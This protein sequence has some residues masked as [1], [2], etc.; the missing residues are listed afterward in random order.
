MKVSEIDIS[1]DFKTIEVQDR[2]YD[3]ID[4]RCLAGMVYQI[5]LIRE[6]EQSLLKLSADGCVHGPVHTSIGQEACAAGTMAVLEP[7]DQIASTHRAHHHYLAK[8]ISCYMAQGFDPRSDDLPEGLDREVTC[9]LGEVMGLSIG[10]CGGRGGSMHLRNKKIGVI[11]TNAIVAGG[12]PLATG[13]AYVMKYTKTPTIVVSFFGD[14]AVNQGA[15]HEALNLAG[16]WKIPIIYFIENN[17]YAVATAV[18]NSTA[19]P[20]LAVKALAYGIRARVVDGMDPLAVMLTVREAKKYALE[21][22]GPTVIEAKCYRFLHH[23]GSLEGSSFSYRTKTEEKEWRDKDPYSVFSQNLINHNI[24][25]NQQIDRI[26]AKAVQT[27]SGAVEYCTHFQK[28]KRCARE[29]LWPSPKTLKLGLKS[30]GCE[31][32]GLL[33]KEI[34]DFSDFEEM[35]YVQAI[36]AVIGRHLERDKTVLIFGEEVANF[37]GGAYGATKGLPVKFP[38]RVFNTPISECGFTGLAGGMAMSGLKP[39]VEIMFP[40]FALVAAD[41]LFNQIGKLRYIYGNSTDMPLVVRTRIAIGCGYGGQHSM[42]PTG[43][44]ALFSGWR[45]LAPSNAFDYIGLFNTAMK[46]GDPVLIIEHHSLYSDKFLVPKSNLDYFIPFGNAKVVK[47]G[48]NVTVLCYSSMVSLALQAA[49]E[50]EKQGIRAEVIDLRTLNIADVDYETIGTSLKKTCVMVILE[51]AAKSNSLGD[52]IAHECENRFFDYLDCPI[53]T[54]AGQ[55]IPN[56]VSRKLETAALPDL[57]SINNLIYR[58]AKKQF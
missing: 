44:F 21:G 7:Q 15:F 38:D 27:V 9:L 24:F 6:F 43:L 20:D 19:I 8:A 46:S 56:P 31:F 12:I 28:G 58:A 22:K 2:D 49:E 51:Q 53:V 45:I 10:C 4:P 5:H 23:A 11:G 14:G 32:A 57:E 37:G 40:D 41:Q 36:S 47:Q 54:L 17:A 33:F 48:G 30:D 39:I 3:K 18:K 16:L 50:L 55:D 13:T 1:F 29:E 52:R 34:E 26:Q 35:T 42:D 25:N